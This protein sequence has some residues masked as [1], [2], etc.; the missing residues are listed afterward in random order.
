M[1]ATQDVVRGLMFVRVFSTCILSNVSSLSLSL[2]MS[3]CIERVIQKGD[4]RKVDDKEVCIKYIRDNRGFS[5]ELNHY[6]HICRAAT[7]VFFVRVC[8]RAYF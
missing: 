7:H 6:L 3:A 1:H 4:D 5:R 8:V 2:S